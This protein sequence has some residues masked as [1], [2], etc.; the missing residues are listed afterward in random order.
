MNIANT[1]ILASI[2][3]ST[4][5]IY[6]RVLIRFKRFVA[7]NFPQTIVF[8]S[9]IIQ[10]MSY[11]AHLFKLG[12]A[13]STLSVHLSAISFIHKINSFTDPTSSFLIKRM[14]LGAK[15]TKNLP[16]TRKPI[17][18]HILYKLVDSIS[19]LAADHYIKALLKSMFLL[20][21]HAFL[22]VG[23][24]TCRSTNCT[25]TCHN[26]LRQNISWS[27]NGATV[28]MQSYKHSNNRSVYLHVPALPDSAYCP[29]EAL[30]N[31]L[32]K[33][34]D[35]AGPLFTF[36]NLKPVTRQF[37]N[38][39]LQTCL[40]LA[41]INDINFKS[42]SFRIGAATTAANNGIPE[43]QIKLMGRWHSDAFKKYI[44]ITMFTT[45]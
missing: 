33:R 29:V 17:Q 19:L 10:V 25:G 36:N 27:I 14:M 20:A 12:M 6:S 44:R 38:T 26:L 2:S 42:H 18:L 28:Y 30:R 32:N 39:Q 4:R 15:K 45:S 34:G 8:P 3:Q 5:T 1:M 16:D 24:I 13:P 43:D 23:E 9:S 21:F 41:G 31:Y 40:R 35:T 22:R 37:F 11:L 7:Y